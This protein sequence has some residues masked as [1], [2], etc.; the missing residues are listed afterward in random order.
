MTQDQPATSSHSM[1]IDPVNR[2]APMEK[3]TSYKGPERR[4][5]HIFVTRHTEYHIREGICVAVKQNENQES[6]VSRQ[7]LNMRMLGYYGPGTLCAHPGPPDLGFSLHFSIQSKFVVTSP[8]VA[9]KRPPKEIADSYPPRTILVVDDD[10]GVRDLIENMLVAKG[11]SVRCAKDGI[12]AIALYKENMATTGL[13]ILDILMPRMGGRQTFAVMKELNPNV[14]ILFISGYC[15]DSLSLEMADKS[16]FGYIRKPF[17]L[18]ELISSVEAGVGRG[19]GMA[20]NIDVLAS[21]PCKK[22]EVSA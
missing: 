3:G 16:V 17:S 8:V 4:I 11:Y 10:Q 20:Y 7:A 9:V 13:V 1:I 21:P 2:K 5:H 22:S 6:A 15:H 19:T 14:R 18:S 12:E